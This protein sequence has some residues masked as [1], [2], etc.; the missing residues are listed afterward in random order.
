MRCCDKGDSSSGAPH[1]YYYYL[2]TFHRNSNLLGIVIIRALHLSSA[3]SYVFPSS[4]ILPLVILC[5]RGCRRI[6]GENALVR[7]SSAYMYL[8]FG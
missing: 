6:G 3:S 8:V 4:H 7:D 2:F 1:G 5:N